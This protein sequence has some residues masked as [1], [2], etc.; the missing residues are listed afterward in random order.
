MPFSEVTRYHHFRSELNCFQTAPFR[1][2]YP[3]PKKRTITSIKEVFFSGKRGAEDTHQT[4]RKGGRDE[5]GEIKEK[6][7]QDRKGGGK[8]NI[9]HG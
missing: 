4:G 5:R 6:A 2:K 7:S 3:P 1:Q 9:H 8:E